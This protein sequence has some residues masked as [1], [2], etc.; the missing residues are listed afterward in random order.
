MSVISD[1]VKLLRHTVCVIS[2]ERTLIRKCVYYILIGLF[3]E[4]RRRMDFAKGLWEAMGEGNK[5]FYFL[6]IS[7]I[8]LKT[9][10]IENIQ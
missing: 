8:I 3:R 9:I 1:K 4:K 2:D 7:A 5:V 6:I 10:P